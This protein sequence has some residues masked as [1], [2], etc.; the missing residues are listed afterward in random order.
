LIARRIAG[1]ARR[2]FR[3]SGRGPADPR[4][5]DLIA[6]VE[7]L[8]S[9]ISGLEEAAGAIGPRRYVAQREF[10][11]P[12]SPGEFMPYST[13]NATDVMH[14]RFA[15]I[16]DALHLEFGWSRKLW[17]WVF[18]THHLLTSGVV[19]PGSRGLVFGVG[20]E[21]LPAFFA[22][23][24]ANVV[25]T[26]APRDVGESSGW[27]ETGQHVSSLETIRYTDIV[28][29]D[30]FDSHVSYRTCDMREIPSD[31]VDFDFNWSSCCFEHLGSLDAG[32]DFVLRAVE[33]LRPGGVAVHTTELNLSSNDETV[34]HGDTVIYRLRDIEALIRALRER[35][36]E[37]T[38]F[39][40][41][42][43]DQ[44][45]DHYV[46]VPPYRGGVHLKLLL[47]GYVCTSVGIVVR[48]GA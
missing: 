26:D 31:L 33:T 19:V 46:D 8:G 21:R 14:P 43:T 16:S 32:I 13:C 6:E 20:E 36:H 30:I 2:A 4:V 29:G 37:V 38:P 11:R 41:G 34:T 5:D 28:D 40:L 15:E 17:E 48:R 27:I 45:W 44:Y 35:G 24:G 47:E 25:A 9:R 3:A 22:G 42:P 10:V 18:I 23:L 1:R 7:R 12:T 39:R